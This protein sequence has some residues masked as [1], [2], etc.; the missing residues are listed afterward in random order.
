VY[1]IPTDDLLRN[2]TYK[3]I[4]YVPIVTQS[5]PT[6]KKPSFKWMEGLR[7]RSGSLSSVVERVCFALTGSVGSIHPV[8]P[9]TL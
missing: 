6:L 5:R 3:G 1:T 7:R 9:L 8:A 4:K 2:L